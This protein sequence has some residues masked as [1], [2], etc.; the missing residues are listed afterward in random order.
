[1]L[2]P[3]GCSDLRLARPALAAAARMPTGASAPTQAGAPVPEAQLLVP[4]TDV[5]AR[6]AGPE[7]GGARPAPASGERRRLS[8]GAALRP[9][10]DS[11]WCWTAR[12]ALPQA[13]MVVHAVAIL[14]CSEQL[15]AA[16]DAEDTPVA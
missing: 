16:P 12:A 2:S 1:M 6:L 13:G 4:R 5:H 14:H 3:R 10:L 8:R 7:R 15:L 9:V 11:G